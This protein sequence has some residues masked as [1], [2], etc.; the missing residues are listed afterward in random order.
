MIDYPYKSDDFASF[1]YCN[2]FVWSHRTKQTTN[3]HTFPATWKYAEFQQHIQS[4]WCMQIAVTF[5]PHW[6]YLASSK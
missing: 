1:L 6:Q 4:H 5:S 2:K 3:Y